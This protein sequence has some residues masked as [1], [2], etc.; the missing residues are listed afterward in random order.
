VEI[1]RDRVVV[2]AGGQRTELRLSTQG[3]PAR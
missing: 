1:T 3:A 2:E